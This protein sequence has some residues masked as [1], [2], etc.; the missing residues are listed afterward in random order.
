MSNPLTELARAL[1][2]MSSNGVCGELQRG[3]RMRPVGRWQAMI[4]ASTLLAGLV[5]GS[6]VMAWEWNGS[7]VHITV[8]E[9]TYIP[10]R[11]TFQA[12]T[13]FSDPSRG[14]ACPA[15]TWLTWKGQGA[16]AGA[17]QSNVEAVYSL[18]LAAKLSGI[19]VNLYGDYA[20]CMATFIHLQ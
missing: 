7:G 14:V 4:A 13:A 16:D 3:I 6:P 11:I 17:K 15:G 19:T 1:T 8:V 10:D 18:L 2:H 20:G 12:D 5:V 9:P